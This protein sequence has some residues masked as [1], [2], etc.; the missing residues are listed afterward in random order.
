M[1][2]SAD[3][4]RRLIKH[5]RGHRIEMLLTMAVV[6]GM[7]RGELLALR[8]SDIDFD[9]GRL[10]VMHTVDFI[11]GY[12]YVEG[13]PKTAAGKRVISLPAF[14]VDM[15]KL[16]RAQQLRQQDTVEGWGNHDLVFPNLS[17]GYL[18]P[19]HM[20]EMFRNLLKEAGLPHMHFHDL[21]HSA[22]TILLCMGVNIKAIQELLG[23]SDISITLRTYSHLLPSMQQ[24]VVEKWDDLFWEGDQESM[25]Q[26]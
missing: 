23:H 2:L 20:G 15:L 1:P 6:T 9:R 4:A 25:G 11:A 17:G 5:V 24:E 21:R 18:H 16:H 19:N 26:R 3:Q 7:R 22:A 12:G 14:L 8:W 13:K 10:L